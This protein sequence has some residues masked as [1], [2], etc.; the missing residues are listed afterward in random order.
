VVVDLLDGAGATLNSFNNGGQPIQV[1]AGATANVAIAFTTSAAT[2]GS[3]AFT[4]TVGSQ[5]ASTTTCPSGTQVTFEAT[6]APATPPAA[7][8]VAC[9]QGT[10]QLDNLPVGN[11]VFKATLSSTTPVVVENIGATVVQGQVAQVTGINFAVAAAA[12]SATVKWTINTQTTSCPSGATVGIVI[13][14]GMATPPTIN[15]ADCALGQTGVQVPNLPPGAG[16]TFE[17]T[18]IDPAH[19]NPNPPVKGSATVEIVA[20]SDAVVTIDMTCCF[21]PGAG[22]PC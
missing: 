12:G 3:V 15:P 2:T 4:W 10:A 22:T 6:T 9:T 7:L 8:T 11:Y 14:A 13:T 17:V 21:C 20:G 18:L 1:V 16:Y 19:V 5:A